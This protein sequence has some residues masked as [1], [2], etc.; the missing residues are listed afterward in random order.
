M[1]YTALVLTQKHADAALAEARC[2]PRRMIRHAEK[3]KRVNN[4]GRVGERDCFCRRRWHPGVG[5]R[6][7]RRGER[8]GQ[9]AAA[10]QEE[11]RTRATQRASFSAEDIP[12]EILGAWVCAVCF[13]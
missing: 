3:D 1:D 5:V 4:D 11:A 9:G 6:S 13:R 10:S 8:W 12:P 7:L 2:V